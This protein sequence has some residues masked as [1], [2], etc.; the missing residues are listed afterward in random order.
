MYILNLGVKGLRFPE[1]SLR[2]QP[3]PVRRLRFPVSRGFEIATSRRETAVSAGYPARGASC[4]YLTRNLTTS[5]PV[6]WISDAHA[7]RNQRPL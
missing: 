2:M 4:S 3:S 7:R 6:P 5:Y 1:R